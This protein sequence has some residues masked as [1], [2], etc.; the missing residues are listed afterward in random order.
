MKKFYLIISCLFFIILIPCSKR[1]G[2]YLPYSGLSTAGK[3]CIYMWRA[4]FTKSNMSS[5]PSSL[6][7]LRDENR[8]RG[9]QGKS[10]EQFM[11]QFL[12]IWPQRCLTTQSRSI[13]ILLPFSFIHFFTILFF[14]F[15]FF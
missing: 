9:N 12:Y 11:L 7:G 2:F 6:Q 13:S 3:F 1:T 8:V 14:L 4:A 10:P 15:Y 5:S